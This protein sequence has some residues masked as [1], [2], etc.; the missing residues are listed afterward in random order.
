[1]IEA[2]KALQ[3]AWRR[4]LLNVPRSWYHAWRA[5]VGLPTAARRRDL[6]I[7]RGCFMQLGLRRDVGVSQH[8]S[9]VR[10]TS[11]VALLASIMR[12]LEL[13][14]VQLRAWRAIPW[15]VTFCNRHLT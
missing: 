2:E 6:G 9:T 4:Q 5:R 12:Q 3:V 13:A 11:S 7:S 10:D 8:S 1:M 15:P 14:A